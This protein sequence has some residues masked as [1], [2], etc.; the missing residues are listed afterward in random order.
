MNTLAAYADIMDRPTW[1]IAVIVLPLLI[2]ALLWRRERD[3]IRR[4]A[5]LG[6]PSMIARIFPTSQPVRPMV[7]LLLLGGAAACAAVAWAGPRWGAE[8]VTIRTAGADVVVAVDAS[9]SMLATDERPS[10]LE[11]AKQDVRR[12]RA[13]SPGDRTALIAFAGRSYILSPLTVDDGALSLFLD[14]LDPSVVGQPGTSIARAIRQGTDLLLATRTASDRALV[15]MSDGEGWESNDDIRAAAEQASKSGVSLVMV[16]YGTEQGSTIP[17]GTGRNPPVK[18]DESGAIV[19]TRYSPTML[20]AAATAGHGTFI[21]A[22]ATD[23]PA[24]VRRALAKL[25]VARRSVEQDDQRTPRFQIFLAPALVLLLLDTLLA[26]PRLASRLASAGRRR[27]VAPTSAPAAAAALVI[28]VALPTPRP[29]S[30][31]PPIQQAATYRRAIEAGD[32]S[33]QTLYNYGTALLEAD[34]VEAAISALSQTADSRD[35]DVRYRSWF[36]LGL[37][38]LRRGLSSDSAKSELDAAL[39]AYKKVLVSRPN[40]GDARWNYELALR[41]RQEGGG[42]GGSGGAGNQAPKPAPA[43]SDGTPSLA[44]RQAEELLNNAAREEREVQSKMQK[45]VQPDVPPGGRD[46]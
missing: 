43:S 18:R 2:A 14:N 42:G 21:P 39:D 10:R 38:H 34:S 1:L 16:G 23:K 3:R 27:R 20:E 37:A 45:Q 36:N 25:R 24:N 4:I 35:A 6:D 30:H 29:P 13:L 33:P 22:T 17:L 11:R 41:K 31:A 15:V 26:D 46:W 44:Q 8:R 5:R 19:V 7:R 32:H 9:L 40:D 28:S 12:L